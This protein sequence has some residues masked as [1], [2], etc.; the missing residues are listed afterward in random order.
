MVYIQSCTFSFSVSILFRLM[1]F[2]AVER[3]LLRE[4]WTVSSTSYIDLQHKEHDLHPLSDWVEG[5]LVSWNSWHLQKLQISAKPA[6]TGHLQKGHEAA[7][8]LAALRSEDEVKR[9]PRPWSCCLMNSG[10]QWITRFMFD[11]QAT[12]VLDAANV[13]PI[14]T[15]YIYN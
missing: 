2:S 14:W 5:D 1:D 11:N 7:E 9:R 4:R 15:M 10:E 3:T 13:Q 12:N 8:A 6:C